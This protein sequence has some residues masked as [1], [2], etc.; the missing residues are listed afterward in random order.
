MAK[1]PETGNEVENKAEDSLESPEITLE[2]AESDGL[3]P[4]AGADEATAE[5][6]DDS[7]EQTIE[8]GVTE[9]EAGPD[10]GEPDDESE[11][12]AEIVGTEET[13]DDDS[14][15]DESDDYIDDEDD[16]D[17]VDEDEDEDELGDEF[18]DDEDPSYDAPDP[19]PAQEVA[20]EVVREVVV[21]RRG[22]FIPMV[23]GGLVAAALG[24]G[25]AWFQGQGDTDLSSDVQTNSSAIDGLTDEVT[26]IVTNVQALSEGP[27]L[28]GIDARLAAI[29]EAVDGTTGRLDALQSELTGGLAGLTERFADIEARLTDVEQR[30]VA[31]GDGGAAL[32]E[33][34]IAAYE[35]EVASLREDMQAQAERLT[36]MTSEAEAQLQAARDEI[37]AADAAAAE[38]ARASEARSAL[39]RVAAAVDTGE[40]FAAALADLTATSG[41]D[42]PAA[43]SA[44]AENGVPT[45][46]ALQESFSEAARAALSVARDEGVD[47]SEGGLGS[48]FRSTFNARS[49]TPREGS[50]PNAVLSRVGAAVE[51]GRINDALAETE[52]LPEVVRAAMSDWLGAAQS[53]A[54][55]QSALETL[56]QL[57]NEN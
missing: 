6:A 12:D 42:V 28:S 54:D 23:I 17:F 32:A 45:T 18:E 33:E 4:D 40:P 19:A 34:A 22:G 9:G 13:D 55:A 3:E 16:D 36:A 7:V 15:D 37:I 47:E 56:S 29:G 30:P 1:S 20:Q 41:V 21:E 31:T 5:A 43:L 26:T 2:S 49:V 11:N 48:L 44:A 39:G 51:G 53:R 24:Y 46:L 52:T 8:D 35:R 50:D 38:A 10:D 25:V 57:V 27:D 14:W